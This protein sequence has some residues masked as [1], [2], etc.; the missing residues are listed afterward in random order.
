MM[1]IKMPKPNI[2]PAKSTG[3]GAPADCSDDGTNAPATAPKAKNG[4]KIRPIQA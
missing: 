3:G 4:R 1:G 2:I